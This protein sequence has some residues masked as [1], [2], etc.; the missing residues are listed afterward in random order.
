MPHDFLPSAPFSTIRR[1][2]CRNLPF[3]CFLCH[4]EFRSIL[5]DLQ[6]RGWMTT[7]IP[8][9]LA[10]LHMAGYSVKNYHIMRCGMSL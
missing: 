10:S 8:T 2:L 6:V 4:A 7:L 5:Q 3:C 1:V 9:E